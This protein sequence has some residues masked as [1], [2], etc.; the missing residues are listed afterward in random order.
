MRTLKALLAAL[1]GLLI[2]AGLATG[3]VVVVAVGAV[4][5]LI[6]AVQRLITGKPFFN[7]KFQVRRGPPPSAASAPRAR[8]LRRVD[9]IDIE[10]TPADEQPKSIEG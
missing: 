3:F 7:V 8:P 5:L 6:L 2:I 9:A 1:I 4:A 10:A